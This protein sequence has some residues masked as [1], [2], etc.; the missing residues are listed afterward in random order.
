MTSLLENKEASRFLNGLNEKVEID[1]NPDVLVVGAGVMGLF[2]ALHLRKILP[3]VQITVVDR[4]EQPNYKIGEST[5][6]NFTKFCNDHVLSPE[7]MLRLF[8]VKDG[9]QFYGVDQPEHGFEDSAHVDIGGLDISYQ[10]ERKMLELLLCRVAQRNGI[11]V[12]FD[13]RV[14]IK[15]SPDDAAAKNIPVFFGGKQMNVDAKFLCDA[16]GE[17]SA[18]A[19]KFQPMARDSNTWNTHAYWAYFKEEDSAA[20]DINLPHW[21][22][23]ATRHICFPEGWIWFIR[24]LSW[25]GNQI[26]NLV[27][28]IDYLLDQHQA[29]VPEDQLPSVAELAKRFGCKYETVMSIG[30]T[31]RSDADNAVTSCKGPEERFNY[32]KNKY[33]V[34]GEAMSHFEITEYTGRKFFQRKTM[35]YRLPQV[36]GRGWLAIGN[37]SGFT[38]PIYSPG[39][40]VGVLHAF[41]AAEVTAKSFFYGDLS[42][43]DLVNGYAQWHTKV[44]DFLVKDVKFW[45]N[46]FRHRELFKAMLGTKMAFIVGN[47]FHNFRSRMMW[48]DLRWVW[49]AFDE[50]FDDYVN[51]TL[52]LLDD[53]FPNGV[54]PPIDE[55]VWTEIRDAGQRLV[56]E[57]LLPNL[58][59]APWDRYFSNYDGKMARK[60]VGTTSM[61]GNYTFSRCSSCAQWRV[62]YMEKCPMCGT[63]TSKPFSYP[64][65]IS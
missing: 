13:C 31:V 39:M 41:H 40:N 21:D 54:L 6:S 4:K 52:A 43:N 62:D 10:V 20:T 3:K 27:K 51:N 26:E 30:V 29:G 17:A 28:M 25:E 58:T 36:A 49:G 45:Y 22:R 48:D 5:L 65:Y 59:T 9:L 46:S 38:N 15:K 19:S 23:F 34:F 7:Y 44:L 35:A 53:T 60:A 8:A 24:L 12:L 42:Q 57:H 61:H 63:K 18:V 37:A 56:E 50:K 55:G 11:Q 2:Y 32:W 64:I 14:D 47:E 16:S 1:A 33:R